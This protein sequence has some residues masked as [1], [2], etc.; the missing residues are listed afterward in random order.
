MYQVIYRSK[1]RSYVVLVLLCGMALS[2]CTTSPTGRNQLLI[3]SPEQAIASSQKAYLKTIQDLDNE[4]KIDTNPVLT[5]RVKKITGKLVAQAIALYPET[6]KWGWSIRVIDSPDTVNAWCMAGGKMAIYTGLIEQIAPTD[7]ELAQVLGHEISHA[8]AN[9]TAE[10]MSVAL[11]TQIA[12]VGTAVA[13]SDKEYANAALVG[14]ALAAT[15]AIELPNSRSAEKE[16]DE[17]G[18]ELAARAGYDP[19]AAVTLWRKMGAKGQRAP[20]EFLS[21]HPSPGNREQRLKALA[22]KM[23]PYYLSPAPRPVYQF[24][25]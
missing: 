18:L 19:E 24:A 2:A 12:L 8:L 3:V 13:V 11:A 7:D 17:L 21:T 14:A 10:K 15:A 9:H 20:F 4:G 22:P 23:Q 25:P 6:A 5:Q 16:A 1:P